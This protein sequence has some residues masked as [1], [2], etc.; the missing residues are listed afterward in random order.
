MPQ[1][2][3]R[4]MWHACSPECCPPYGFHTANWLPECARTGEDI[5]RIGPQFF[6]PFAQNAISQIR[7]WKGF[8]GTRCLYVVTQA[9]EPML[10]IHLVPTQPEPFAVSP[11]SRLDEQNNAHAKMRRGRFQNAVL[12]IQCEQLFVW[13]LAEFVE[14]LHSTSRIFWDVLAACCKVHHAREAFEFA[15][16]GSALEGATLIAKGGL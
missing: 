1:V 7:K 10:P 12:L 6:F 13:P 16:D 15:I 5:R 4:K 2:V 11:S 14:V 9:N 8:G 3:N